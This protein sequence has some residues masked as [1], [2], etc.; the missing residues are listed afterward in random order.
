MLWTVNIR[1]EMDMIEQS[2]VLSSE[3]EKKLGFL[4][5]NIFYGENNQRDLRQREQGCTGEMC[6]ITWST[7]TRGEPDRQGEQEWSGG[8][9]PRPLTPV[10]PGL[11]IHP[12]PDAR[13]IDMAAHAR[14]SQARGAKQGGGRCPLRRN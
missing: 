6:A 2:T 4:L 11:H 7:S 1:C 3:R 10:E 8:E 14:P 13:E 9:S 12:P 5:E